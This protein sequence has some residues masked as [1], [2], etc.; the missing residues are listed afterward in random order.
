MSDQEKGFYGWM[1]HQLGVPQCAP[2]EVVVLDETN[3]PNE[4]SHTEVTRN[5]SSA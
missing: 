1:C 3:L 5:A 2:Y 4:S